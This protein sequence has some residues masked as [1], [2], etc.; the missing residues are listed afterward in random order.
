MIKNRL[1]LILW[2]VV[3]VF[4]TITFLVFR[5][6][7]ALFETNAHGIVNNAI[8][9]WVIKLSNNIISSGVNEELNI[10]NFIYENN[11][12][13]ETGYIAPGTS[14]YFDLVFDATL[15]DVAVKY[16]I[17]FRIDEI[18]YSDN[19]RFRI[20]ELNGGESIRT[21]ENTYSGVISLEKIASHTLVTIRVNLDWVDDG[22]HDSEDTE[23]GIVS[24]NQLS[25]PISVRAVQYLGEEIV[26]YQEPEPEP[27]PEPN[28]G[29]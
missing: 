17:N 7:Y 18:D 23:L 24:G 8:G 6:T 16:D 27:D 10:D 15:C 11:S 28:Q 20:E 25:V 5:N 22:E 13:V 29:E 9:R 14:A 2:L 4:I 21:A 26:E 1:R 12:T 19:I 3:I